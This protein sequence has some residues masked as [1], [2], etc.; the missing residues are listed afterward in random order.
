MIDAHS[1]FTASCS[2]FTGTPSCISCT[3]GTMNLHEPN[4][5]SQCNADSQ[6]FSIQTSPGGGFV[7]KARI[8]L[9]QVAWDWNHLNL[10]VTTSPS[11]STYCAS[12]KNADVLAPTTTD[13]VAITANGAFLPGR[14]EQDGLVEDAW[15][16]VE[17]TRN[18]NNEFQIK[19]DGN[20][21]IPWQAHSTPV[22]TQDLHY[23]RILASNTLTIPFNSS[24]TN[25]SLCPY[26]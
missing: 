24:V 4:S 11:T 16:D 10:C 21:I 17:F 25:L 9:A 5:G 7:L 2:G 13:W 22:P 1:G 20:V 26:Q 14:I 8:Q 19:M 12:F 18:T 15:H 3:G 6:T 23:L